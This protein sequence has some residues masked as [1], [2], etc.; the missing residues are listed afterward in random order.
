MHSHGRNNSIS[1]VSEL[2]TSSD[3]WVISKPE[4]STYVRNTPVHFWDGYYSQGERNIMTYDGIR[5]PCIVW[6]LNRIQQIYDNDSY[7]KKK[8]IPSDAPGGDK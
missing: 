4:P 6:I 3:H 8:Y 5:Y 1:F 7:I 2:T